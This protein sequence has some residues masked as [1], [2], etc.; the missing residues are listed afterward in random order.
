MSDSISPQASEENILLLA[1]APCLVFLLVAAADGS[2]DKKEI[3][4]FAKLLR[5]KDYRELGAAIQQSGL[6]VLQLMTS[7]R[8]QTDDPLE[9]LK[10]VSGLLDRHLKP[11]AAGAFK[12]TLLAFAKAIAEASGGF[13]GLFGSKISK[14]E[15]AALYLIADALGLLNAADTETA[16]SEAV[17]G[18]PVELGDDVYPVLKSSDWASGSRGEVIMRSVYLTEEVEPDEPVVAYGIDVPET[19]RF[20]NTDELPGTLSVEDLHD[21]AMANLERRLTNVDWEELSHETGIE[22]LPEVRG[23]VLAGDYYCS[24][25]LLSERLLKQAHE[26]LGAAMMMAIAPVRGQLYVCRL[27]AEE[28]P[29]PESL[30]F[31]H[32]ALTR[33]FNPPDAPIAP[34]AWIVRNGKVVGHVNGMDAVVESARKAAEKEVEDEESKLHHMATTIVTDDDQFRLRVTVTA[35][36]VAIMLRNLQ[37]ALR[38][39]VHSAVERE[40]FSGLVDVNVRIEDGSYTPDDR[41]ELSGLMDDMFEFLNNQF[42]S[43]GLTGTGDQPI[44]LAY[45]LEN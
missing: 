35:F 26:K 34:K 8:Q 18:S 25:A 40:G 20:I 9:E 30:V 36:D 33:Y 41:T 38:G 43:H 14:E 11:G 10:R 2:I 19:V 16:P 31:A 12:A 42:A 15:K 37:Y 13:L 44:R 29:S 22:E 1:R 5:H 4:R 39:Y 32:F 28:G 7:V 17:F 21:K 27:P 45:Q 3:K 23:F 24:E 6:S